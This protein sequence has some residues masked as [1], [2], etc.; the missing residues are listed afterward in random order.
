[1]LFLCYFSI[2]FCTRIYNQLN[3]LSRPPNLFTHSVD[4]LNVVWWHC[5]HICYVESHQ[6]I[7]FINIY[8]EFTIRYFNDS[9]YFSFLPSSVEY[10]FGNQKGKNTSCRRLSAQTQTTFQLH[11][12]FFG[13]RHILHNEH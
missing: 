5:M 3:L 2:I 11:N 4:V 7:Y 8:L 13:E 12:I 6:T 10:I 1:M 9:K